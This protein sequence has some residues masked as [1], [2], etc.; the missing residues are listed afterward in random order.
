MSPI[1]LTMCPLHNKKEALQDTPK[2]L[3]TKNSYSTSLSWSLKFPKY[4]L[5]GIKAIEAI[6]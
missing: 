5:F 1:F 2:E 3:P 6:F 4:S